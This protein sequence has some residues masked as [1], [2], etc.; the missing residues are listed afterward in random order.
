MPLYEYECRTCSEQFEALVRSSEKDDP[1]TCPACGG[2]KSGRMLSTF[3]VG[4]AAKPRS[5]C[6]T[7]PQG[8]VCDR[9][10]G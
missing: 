8:S 9:M 1:K 6:A 3:A 4:T 5:E 10:G 7:C 2:E